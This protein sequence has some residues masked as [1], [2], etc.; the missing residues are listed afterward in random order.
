MKATQT[1]RLSRALATLA[2]TMAPMLVC[3]PAVAQQNDPL[4]VP[5]TDDDSCEFGYRMAKNK[6]WE[7]PAIAANP[8]AWMQLVLGQALKYCKLRSLLMIGTDGRDV[9]GWDHD[10]Y[11]VAGMLCRRGE[12]QERNVKVTAIAFT[13]VVFTCPINPSKFEALQA[14]AARGEPLWNYPQDWIAGRP[15]DRSALFRTP[16]KPA[17][18][19]DDAASSVSAS[20]SALDP[21]VMP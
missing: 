1:A 14:R 4:P 8:L 3:L 9:R 7:N 2:L 17:P 12:I 19:A 10:Y 6:V 13:G 11:T 18:P 15:S 21:T 20:A 5:V 16:K